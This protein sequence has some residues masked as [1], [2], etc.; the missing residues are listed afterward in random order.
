MSRRSR[1]RYRRELCLSLIIGGTVLALIL[2][3]G[4]LGLES[5][6]VAFAWRVHA[7]LID[8][9]GPVVA[10]SGARDGC[11][12]NHAATITLTAT[13]DAVGSGVASITYALDGVSRTIAGSMVQVRVPAVPNATHT[14][15]YHATDNA[16]TVGKTRT[17]TVNINT[18]GPTIA[19]KTAKGTKGKTMALKYRISDAASSSATA[20]TVVIRDSHGK[21]EKRYA[22]GSESIGGWHRVH[23]TPRAQGTYSYAVSAK[24]IAGNRE[25]SLSKAKIVVEWPTWLT[26]GRSVQNR[27]IVV[28]QFGTGSHRL[29]IVGGVHP[30]EAG[31]AV[32]RLFAAYLAVHPKAVPVGW[33]I[34]VIPCLNPD[35]LAHKSRGNADDVDLNRNFP[36]SNWRHTLRKGDP[37]YSCGLNGGRYAGSEPETKALVAYLRQGFAVELSLHSNAGILDCRGPGGLALGERMSALCG[38]PVGRLSYES[39]ITGSSEMYVSEHYRIPSITVELRSAELSSRLCRALL[40]A[41]H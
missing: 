34:D 31:T 7:L 28:A 40:A 2:V 5:H 9:S 30:M 38:L 13:D 6:A 26:I 4:A 32:A 3:A 11:W 27:R 35:G 21:V 15:V 14:L 39:L 8:S 19:T 18:V 10:A 22:I 12:L 29:L 1:P 25:I 16:G 37:S 41:C 33:R 17:L 36:S 20:I 24:D 23:W